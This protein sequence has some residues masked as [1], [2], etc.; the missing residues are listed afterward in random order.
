MRPDVTI[1]ERPARMMELVSALATEIAGLESRVGHLYVTLSIGATSFVDVS[2]GRDIS[3]EG[4]RA[5]YTARVL[6]VR[7]TEMQ[8]VAARVVA[9]AEARIT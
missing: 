1:R 3:M 2:I 7:R 5:T 8:S 4:A 9:G 6:L